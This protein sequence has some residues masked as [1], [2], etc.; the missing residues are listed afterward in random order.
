MV[1]NVNTDTELVTSLKPFCMFGV[2][3]RQQK[4]AAHWPL[5]DAGL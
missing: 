4:L 5:K 2:Q 1:L 3:K